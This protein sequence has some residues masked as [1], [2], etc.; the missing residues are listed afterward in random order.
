[1]AV[2]YGMTELPTAGEVLVT[3]QAVA[4]VNTRH[5]AIRQFTAKKTQK[6]N[7]RR[8]TGAAATNA[9]QKI[10]KTRKLWQQISSHNP[11]E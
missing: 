7:N 8:T 2:G 1:M 6:V 9:F 3:K 4:R 5:V 10:R 11:G